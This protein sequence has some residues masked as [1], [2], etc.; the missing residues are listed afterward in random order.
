M[1]NHYWNVSEKTTVNTNLAYQTGTIKNS[2]I[3]NG[4]L[5][6]PAPDYYQLLPSFA[7]QDENPTAN[8]F[9]NAFLLQQDFVNNGQFD[10][11]QTYESNINSSGPVSLGNIVLQNDVIED[12]QLTANVIVNSQLTENI[13][14]NGNLNYKDLSSENYAE[15]EDLLGCL[16][17]TSPSPRDR[18]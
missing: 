5:R 11:E 13:T 16:L 12:T 18:G 10:W 9:Q 2:R 14:L 1:L 15:I 7:L 4:R 6:N 3:D 17:Y 8:D